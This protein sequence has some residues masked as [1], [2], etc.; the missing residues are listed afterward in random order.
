LVGL[1][2]DFTI[3]STALELHATF[4]GCTGLVSLP[5]TFTLE[6]MEFNSFRYMF[7]N[8]T[9]LVSLPANFRLTTNST[10]GDF[11]DATGMFQGCSKLVTIPT[12]L[13]VGVAAESHITFLGTFAYCSALTNLPLLPQQSMNLEGAFANCT[14]IT[15]FP[16][17]FKIPRDVTNLNS[18]FIN[19]LALEE[20]PGTIWPSGDYT[21]ANTDIDI[22]SMF[23][24]YTDQ[25]T[26]PIGTIPSELWTTYASI[27]LD[28]TS[29]FFNC[30]SLTNYADIPV[31]WK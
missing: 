25:S 26:K 27:F 21:W 3:P 7:Q 28:T 29:A 1:P 12:T 20:I 5:T 18:T 14:S 6:H 11:I 4:K 8:C 24:R 13:F 17:G 16:A 19:N 30:S 23:F 9:E 22:G 31:S 15:Q 10:N 2:V